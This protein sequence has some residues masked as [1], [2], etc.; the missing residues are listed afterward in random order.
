VYSLYRPGRRSGYH[1]GRTRQKETLKP[2]SGLDCMFL[3]Q[4]PATPMHVG[5]A[6]LLELPG[7][8]R[9]YVAEVK[10][11]VARRLHLSPVF[12]RQLAPMP[13]D[14]A[15]P[16][17]IRADRVDLD[18]HVLRV[19]LPKPGTMAQLEA[20]IARLHSKPLDRDQPLWAFHVIEGLQSGQPAF[21]TKIHHA[22]LDGASGVLLAQALLDVS[23]KPRTVE[24][25][26][27]KPGEHPSLGDLIG[28][29]LKASGTQTAKLVRHLPT[30]AKVVAARDRRCRR[31][32][33][34]T[35]RSVPALPS[36]TRSNWRAFAAQRRCRSI[37][38][39]GSRP[40]AKRNSTMSC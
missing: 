2:L 12:T 30:F 23:P 25:A 1:R 22:T 32:S 37:A 27:T 33:A 35:S 7:Y 39:S 36:T 29:A 20:T 18:R 28:T 31:L 11:H 4:T 13:L 24:R 14:F 19:R 17:W 38:S 9:D 6:H 26:R 10:R 16:V 21:Y 3:H 8:R 15:N 40:P 34:A 5:A